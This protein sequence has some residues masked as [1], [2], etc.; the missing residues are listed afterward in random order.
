MNVNVVITE[1]KKR[2]YKIKM[3]LNALMSEINRAI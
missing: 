3:C 2:S 1:L